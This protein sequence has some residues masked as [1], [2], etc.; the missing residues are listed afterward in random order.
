MGRQ[1]SHGH[2]NGLQTES[3]RTVWEAL[4]V[5][6]GHRIKQNDIFGH[7]IMLKCI[8]RRWNGFVKF[9]LVK[10]VLEEGT[11][12][13]WPLV[14]FAHAFEPKTKRVFLWRLPLC[15]IVFLVH[16]GWLC[17]CKSWF[18]VPA[19]LPSRPVSSNPPRLIDPRES[20]Y[21]WRPY[22]RVTRAC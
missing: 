7:D 1:L 8:P 22:P 19:S 20:D 17:L 2:P 5:S 9:D 3:L 13:W 12:I 4:F 14:Y 21:L 15:Y 18:D 10:L 11:S 6:P 16:N